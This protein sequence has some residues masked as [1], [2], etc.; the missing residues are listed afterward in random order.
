MLPAQIAAHCASAV[1]GGTMFYLW[2]RLLQE[3]QQQVWRLYVL[4]EVF[5]H[6]IIVTFSPGTDGSARSCCAAAASAP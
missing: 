6:S 4:L 2:R 3:E 1:A 5:P